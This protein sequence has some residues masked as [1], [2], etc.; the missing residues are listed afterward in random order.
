ML[1]CIENKATYC[2]VLCNFTTY[3]VM[4]KKELFHSHLNGWKS[5]NIRIINGNDFH[6]I[7][8]ML[9]VDPFLHFTIHVHDFFSH[10]P[11]TLS[12]DPLQFVS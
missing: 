2:A 3:S 5:R 12:L 10:I 7:H 4:A 8:H 11:L 9:L 6:L 1:A